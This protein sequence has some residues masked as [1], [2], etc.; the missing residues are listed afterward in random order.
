[1]IKKILKRRE[2]NLLIFIILLILLVS[3]RSHNFLKLKNFGDIFEDTS[4]LL[5]VSIAQFMVILIGGIDLSVASG[6]GLSGMSVAMLNQFYPEIPMLVILL[7]SLIIGF[8]LGS[9]NGLL[10]SHANIPPIITTL[11]TMSIYRGFIFVMSKGNWVS[12]HEMSETFRDFPKDNPLLLSNLMLI[13]ITTFI[14]FAI[15]IKYTKTG[16]E[17]YGI[18]GKETASKLVGINIKKIK[19]ISFVL[20]GIIVGAAG[21]LWVARYASA[22][23][24]TASGF[25]LQTVAACVIGGVSISGG[26]GTI[27]GVLL[28]SIFMGILNNALTQINISPFWQMAIQGFIILIAIIANTLMDQ[29]TQKQI[30]LRRSK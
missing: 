20:A 24:E 10:V 21:F 4:I 26:S 19:Y 11:G 16:R 9:F 15:F 22:Q 30:L 17:L 12:A 6:I 23:N 25:E 27:W 7:I 2:I 29:R 18:G 3:L 1:M 13:A 28:G 8:I 14:I 5:M